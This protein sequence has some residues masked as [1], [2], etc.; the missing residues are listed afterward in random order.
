MG[1]LVKPGTFHVKAIKLGS[2]NPLTGY[3][4]T[5]DWS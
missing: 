4:S 1:Q 2:L 5:N 3:S